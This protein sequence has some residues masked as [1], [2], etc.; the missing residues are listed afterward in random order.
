M[1]F[2]SLSERLQGT[3]KKVTGQSQLT[4][5]NM[6]EML[7]EIRLALL[8]A[9]VNYE[10]VKDFIAK[11]KEKALGA[12]VLGSLKPGQVVVKIVHDELVELL[13]TDVSTVDFSKKPTII[14]MVGL[15]G[16]GKT[17]TT[18]KIAKRIKEKDGKK[19][20][21]VAADIYRP[22]AVEQLKTIGQQVDVEVFSEGT[23]VSAEKIVTDA[24]DHA[25]ENHNDVILIDTAGRLQIDQP[26]MEELKHLKDI[27]HPDEILL[28]VDSLAGQE[29]ANVASSFND[30]LG[31]TGAV[32]TKLD[33]DSRGGGAI[34]IRYLTHVPI[35]YIGTGEK[36][37]QIDLFYPDRMAERILGMGDVVSL[38][39]KVQ[40]VYDEKE[41][42]KAFNKMQRGTFGL[43]DM[44]VQ[45]KQLKKMGPLSGILKMLPGMPKMPKIDDDE[46]NDRLKETESMI[47]SMTLEERQHPEIINMKRRE[48]IAKGSG[49]SVADVNR[50]LKQFEQSKKMMKQLSNIDPTTGMMTQKPQRSNFNPAGGPH[51]KVRHKKKKKR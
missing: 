46:A 31:I 38:V 17:T 2:E 8:E 40:D 32:L 49:K 6:E 27:A 47:L 11:T 36:L 5:Q 10:V 34:S 39:E 48:R 20:L 30:Q 29:I 3:L 7:R 26:L 22:A 45:M 42:M 19:P 21:L 12:D 37:D 16:S 13:G 15:Q 14:M 44:L 43:D 33:G 35:K 24:L 28:V 18:G 1:A 25:K 4:E 23:D 41:S 50:L 51:K 9:D